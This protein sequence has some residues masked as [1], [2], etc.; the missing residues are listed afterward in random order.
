MQHETEAAPVPGDD[1]LRR[2]SALSGDWFWVQDA[3]LRLTYMS[4]RPAEHAGVDLALYLGARRW[5]Q[6]ALNLTE[7]D[8]QRHQAQVHRHEA[9]KDF[10][11]QCPA[12]DGRTVW[13]SLSAQPLFDEDGRFSGYLGVGRDITQQKRIEQLRRLEHG[14]ARALAE[15]ANVVESVQAMLQTIGEAEGWECAEFWRGDE[16]AWGLQLF[17]RWAAPGESLKSPNALASAVWQSGEPL[18]IADAS[19]DPRIVGGRVPEEPG[20]QAAVFLPVGHTG[21]VLGVLALASR[22]AR[23][24]DPQVLESLEAIA[25]NLALVVQRASAERTL[26]DGDAR[27]RSLTHLAADWYWELDASYSF[28]RLEGRNVAGGDKDLARRLIGV[29]RWESGLEVEGGWERHRALLDARKPFYD[30][31][32]WR[33][34]PDG[35][36]RYMSISGEPVFRPDGSFAGYHGVGREMREAAKAR[37]A[38]AKRLLR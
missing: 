35:G 13:L 23:A 34:M 12:D 19:R 9:F 33:R 22:R 38:I 1:P 7:A 8:W 6:P 20:L 10:E 2:F 17:E 16:K 29:R 28:T 27:F 4:S 32:M 36:M 26:R 30:V 25:S 14:A 18:W 21:R 15:G 3:Q 37:V 31:L 5:D 11:L 24:S